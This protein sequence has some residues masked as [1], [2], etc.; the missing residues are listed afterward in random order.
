MTQKKV[1]V[2][3]CDEAAGKLYIVFHT[4]CKCEVRRTEVFY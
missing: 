3:D 4:Q 2:A 1:L